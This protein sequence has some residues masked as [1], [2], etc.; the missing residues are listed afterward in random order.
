VVASASYAARKF[1]IHSAMPMARAARLCPELKIVPAD[2]SRI[3]E[4]SRQVM[5][6]LEEYGPV[7]KMSVDEAYIDLGE[8]VDPLP[9][10]EEVRTAVT[11]QTALPASVGL[12]TSKLVAKVASDHEKPAGC[13]IILPGAEAAFL[14]PLPTRA[15]WGIGPRTAEKLARLGIETCRQ[16]AAADRVTLHRHFGAQGESLKRRANGEDRRPVQAERG[17]PKSISQETTFRRDVD[18]PD[19]LRGQLEKMAQQVARSLQ[20]KELAARTVKVKFRWADFTTFTRQTSVAVPF[21]DAAQLYRLAEHL[22]AENW[23]P[24]QKMRLIGVGVA[25]LEERHGRQLA[26]EFG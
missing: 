17:R 1:G 14:A 16:L 23:P 20:K 4:C 21:D 24:G 18:D 19:Y 7:E 8:W 13:T 6:I 22:W 25:N 2:W 11:N 9:L 15:I 5:A 12:A 26:F 10:A 3:H